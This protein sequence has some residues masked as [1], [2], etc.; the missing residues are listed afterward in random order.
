[1]TARGGEAIKR[2]CGVIHRWPW[3]TFLTLSQWALVAALCPVTTRIDN[4]DIGGRNDA[5]DNAGMAG[6][7]ILRNPREGTC[8]SPVCRNCRRTKA[9]WGRSSEG[10]ALT[11]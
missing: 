8:R 10:F 11:R 3:R 4:A 5:D 6:T 1:M 7:H 2:M 9:R